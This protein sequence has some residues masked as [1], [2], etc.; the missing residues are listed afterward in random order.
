MK[1]IKA[2]AVKFDKQ[3]SGISCFCVLEPEPNLDGE[4]YKVKCKCSAHSK[5]GW[6]YLDSLA[7]FDKRKEAESWRESNK[8]FKVIPVEIK[9]L[10]TRVSIQ[11]K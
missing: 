2:W 1:I 11:K 8:D 9:E 5:K 10:N 7:I 6:H 3:E 4:K